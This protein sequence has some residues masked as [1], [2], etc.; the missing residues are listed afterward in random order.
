MDNNT[1][2]EIYSTIERYINQKRTH[3][4]YID[5]FELY[6][7]NPDIDENSLKKETRKVRK[8]FHP[9]QKVYIDKR[10]FDI[11]D[12]II[13]KNTKFYAIFDNK[14]KVKK[15][16]EELQKRKNQNI[17]NNTK[18]KNEDLEFKIN[19]N[20]FQRAIEAMI[21]K[22]G[23]SNAYSGITE[24]LKTKDF[25]KITRD[26]NAR[27]SLK[28]I[29]YES[30]V[31]IIK[32]YNRNENYV[33]NTMD[34]FLSVMKNPSISKR[35]N[36]FYSSCANVEINN[37]SSNMLYSLL[38][39][40]LLYN[41]KTSLDYLDK[42]YINTRGTRKEFSTQDINFLMYAKLHENRNLNE[43]FAF[44][45]L[46]FDVQKY[47]ENGFHYVLASYCDY[48]KKSVKTQNMSY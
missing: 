9:D 28:E 26:R 40:Y 11:Y 42:D 30:V 19:L 35:A 45:K 43:N 10:Y 22:Y 5:F 38:E 37:K 44:S 17:V 32:N 16:Y 23:F 21:I 12:E 3:T 39:N 47:G 24:F 7:I 1:L 46:S 4:N 14:E 29:G 33:D 18:E 20:I 15:Y 13:N 41:N 8:L 48:I 2:K 34:I 25:S 6:Q 36:D 31:E 27:S